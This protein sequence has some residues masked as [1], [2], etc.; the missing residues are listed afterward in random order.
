M[1]VDTLFIK[2]MLHKPLLIDQRDKVF[3]THPLIYIFFAFAGNC[4]RIIVT[5]L[6][7]KHEVGSEFSIVVA[8]KRD[9]FRVL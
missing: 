6:K 8:P 1:P 9:I 3:R 2:F 7:N 5:F 4:A